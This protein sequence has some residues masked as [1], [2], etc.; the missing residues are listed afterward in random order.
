MFDMDFTVSIDELEQGLLA[1]EHAI[2][3]LRQQQAEMLRSLDAM[4]VHRID[5]ARSLQE[6]VRGRIDVTPQTARD[7]VDAAR[8]DQGQP[9]IAK[10]VEC[11]AI[12]FERLVATTRLATS[13]ADEETVADSFGFDLAGVARLRSRHRRITR[14][15]EQDVF[16]D[17]HLFLQ[18]SLDGARGR[19]HGEMPGYEYRIF[20]KAMEERADMFADLPG[21]RIAKPQ[22]LIDALVSISQDSLDLPG[23]NGEP[24]N[25]SEPIVTVLVDGAL[26]ARTQGE[27]GAEIEFGPR[28]GPGVL[29]RILC[30][31][32]VQLVGL[33][34]GKPVA[35]SNMTRTIPPATRRFVGW[36]DGDCIIDGCH[37]RYRLQPHHVRPWAES[38]DHDPDN[39][40]T[41][42]WFHHHVVVHSMGLRID[43]TSP[44]QKRR[45]LRTHPG[46]ADP[47]SD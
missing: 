20:T 36:R 19:F 44:P 45:F 42:C 37:S 16:V 7:L 6:W 27:A 39:L 24:S 40:T 14:S 23:P 41:L 12:S 38:Q 5:G 29:E 1:R 13:G 43:P 31:G 22:R 8:M 28:V 35:T 15:S 11:Q 47:P 2:S 18:D 30:G 9:G 3:A 21:P 46:G 33:A 25:R 10:L 4:Q 32:R 26:A 17:R 34:N